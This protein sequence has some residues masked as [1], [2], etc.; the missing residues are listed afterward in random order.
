MASDI[1]FT[2]KA[3]I[4]GKKED[5][6]SVCCFYQ[7][8]FHSISLARTGLHALLQR[9]LVKWAFSLLTSKEEGEHNLAVVVGLSNR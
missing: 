7:E 6:S 5:S 4:M 1:L 8:N 2:F 9:M 3:G